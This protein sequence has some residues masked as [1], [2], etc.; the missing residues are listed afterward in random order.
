M[1]SD[2]GI[3]RSKA[4]LFIIFGNILILIFGPVLLY[5]VDVEIYRMLAPRI[6]RAN[7]TIIQ[8]VF[9]IAMGMLWLYLW[10]KSFMTLFK[11]LL[12]RRRS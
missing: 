10:R 6:G 8:A 7:T 11:I 2:M 4:L 3:S 9:S 12:K 5:S 1:V